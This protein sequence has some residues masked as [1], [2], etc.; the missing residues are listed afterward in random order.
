MSEGRKDDAGKRQW[1]LLELKL[2]EP[3]VKVLEYGAHKYARDNWR[4]FETDDAIR[5]YQEAM[6][7]HVATWQSGQLRDPESNLPHL[8]HIACCAIFLMHYER[9]KYPLE[10][11]REP[12]LLAPKASDSETSRSHVDAILGRDFLEEP[13]VA[14]RRASKKRTRIRTSTRRASPKTR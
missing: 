13:T 10:Y 6:L 4:E 3:V 14:A 12:N 1:S 5:R 9:G 11:A 2:V 8:A 7:R